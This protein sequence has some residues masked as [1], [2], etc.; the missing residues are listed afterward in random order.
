MINKFDQTDFSVLGE[1]ERVVPMYKPVYAFLKRMFDI[2]LSVLAMIILSPVFLITAVI[3]FAQDGGNPF[4]VSTRITVNGRP[5]R[6]YKFRSMVKDADKRKHELE[7]HNEIKDGPA[8][9]M[10]N[11]PRITAFGRFIRKTSIDEL[12]QLLNI[13]KGDMTIVGPRP[14]IPTEVEW[15]TPYQMQRLSVKQGLTCYWQCSGRNEIGFDE[16]MRLDVQ[17]IRDRSLWTDIKILFKTVGAV[18]TMRGAK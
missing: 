18:I 17:Y 2:I 16:W 12:P 7:K 14:P 6:M 3:I 5:F 11:D 8:F 9:K 10:T 13:L 15:Y 4:Y 1:D